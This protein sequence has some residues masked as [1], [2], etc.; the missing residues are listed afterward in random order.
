MDPALH[1]LIECLHRAPGKWVLALTGGGTGA[2][3][4]LLSVPGGSRAVLEIQVPYDEQALTEFL[5]RRPAS[6]CSRETSRDMANRAYDRARWLAPTEPVAGLG[7]TAS[8]ATDR[9]KRGEHRLHLAVRTDAGLTTFSLTLSKG[10]RDRRGE[11]LLLD[12]LLLN[13]MAQASGVEERVPVPLLG[14]EEIQV[15]AVR[16]ADALTAFPNAEV[17]AICAEPDGRLSPRMARP[18]L[19]ISGAFNPLHDGHVGM[20]RAASRV[21]GL[22]EA[23]ELSVTNVDKAPLPVE[24][25]RRRLHQFTWRA[26]VWLTRAPTFAEKASLFPG[27]L[28]V[29]GADTAGRIVAPRYYDH[30]GAQ[31]TQALDHLRAQGC[32]FLVAGRVDASGRFVGLSDLAIPAPH[33]DLFT[34]LPESEFRCDISSTHLRA[35]E[36]SGS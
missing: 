18:T 13:A 1:H 34:Q 17:P 27:A 11:E 21:T 29:V 12:R 31:M 19:L 22:P 28:F 24:E 10:A 33:T 25:I 5:G 3:A 35:G 32:R 8:L 14:G 4:M 2:A 26:P 36:A 23:F 20:A 6:F 30:S 9:P 7:C 16:A 15:D